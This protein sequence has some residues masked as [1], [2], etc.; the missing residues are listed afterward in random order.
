MTKEV[1]AY[2][3]EE[4]VARIKKKFPETKGMTAT[5]L[6]DWALRYLLKLQAAEYMSE[7][8]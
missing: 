4:L 6:V 5:G 8:A 7:G 1:R 3:N 2:V